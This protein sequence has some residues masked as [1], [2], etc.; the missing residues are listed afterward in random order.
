VTAPRRQVRATAD[1]FL[2]LDQQLPAA[3]GGRLP[4]RSDFET[5][6]LLK[7]VERCAT[8]FD[9]LPELIPG[10]PEYRVLIVAGRLVP[11]I[12]VTA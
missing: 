7:I 1:F 11:R 4:S 6:E 10:R 9:E 8:G 2:E 5:T 3:R 12:S